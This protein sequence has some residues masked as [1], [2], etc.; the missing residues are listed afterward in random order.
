MSPSV[1]TISEGLRGFFAAL[2]DVRVV[3]ADT[4]ANEN[5]TKNAASAVFICP[6]TDLWKYN[7]NIKRQQVPNYD[8]F[9]SYNPHTLGRPCLVFG[10]RAVGPVWPLFELVHILDKSLSRKSDTGIQT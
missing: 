6:R 2:E 10:P 7:G 1:E 8:G 5:K 4:V 9:F 3:R